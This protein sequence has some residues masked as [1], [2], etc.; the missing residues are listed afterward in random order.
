ML[1]FSLFVFSEER[2][3]RGRASL[4]LL[5]LHVSQLETIRSSIEFVSMR[6]LLQ[7]I[8]SLLRYIRRKLA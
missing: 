5:L 6:I 7:W 1:L 2:A 3:I 4:L 8:L